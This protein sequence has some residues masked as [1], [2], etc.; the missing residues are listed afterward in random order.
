MKYIEMLSHTGVAVMTTDQVGTPQEKQYYR[1]ITE[2]AGKLFFSSED[3]YL[4]WIENGR[5]YRG[6]VEAGR[7]LRRANN[8]RKSLQSLAID[9]ED[10]S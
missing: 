1:V 9:V 8:N 7:P 3:E 5:L 2:H 4:R 6:V 10:D